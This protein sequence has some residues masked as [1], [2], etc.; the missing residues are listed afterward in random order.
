MEKKTRYSKVRTVNFEDDIHCMPQ[1]DFEE[2]I[3]D[4]N[5]W[6]SPKLDEKNLQDIRRGLAA[7]YV[8]VHNQIKY[9]KQEMN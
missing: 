8:W 2:H 1:D 3:P 7:H 4:A 9:N 5:C 6:C